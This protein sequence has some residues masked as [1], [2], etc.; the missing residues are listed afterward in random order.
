MA[1]HERASQQVLWKS[2]QVLMEEKGSKFVY[3]ITQLTVKPPPY[4][5][6]LFNIYHEDLKFA[7]PEGW[8]N[9]MGAEKG[10]VL[11][12]IEAQALPQLRYAFH[13][14][15]YFNYEIQKCFYFPADG[16]LVFKF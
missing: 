13:Q 7:C 1:W 12:K 5:T 14:G 10:I 2:H 6:E 3:P 8:N 4:S 16:F 11:P 15:F 9:A